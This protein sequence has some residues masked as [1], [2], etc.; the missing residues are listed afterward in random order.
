MYLTPLVLTW[1]RE[2]PMYGLSPMRISKSAIEIKKPSTLKKSFQLC[3][4]S[5]LFQQ[6]RPS[7]KYI[8]A[9]IKQKINSAGSRS[10]TKFSWGIFGLFCSG[11]LSII[12]K[13][14]V[15]MLRARLA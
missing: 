13:N 15:R 10:S 7:P 8:E 11:G 5:K 2:G 14:I 3:A 6:Y 12:E 1:S 4:S 9:I